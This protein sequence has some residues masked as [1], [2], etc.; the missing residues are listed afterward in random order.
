MEAGPQVFWNR[1]V[2]YIVWVGYS[3]VEGQRLAVR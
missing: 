2:D 1:V 3:T